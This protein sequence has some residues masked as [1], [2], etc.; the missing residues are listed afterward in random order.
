MSMQDPIADLLTRIRNGQMAGKVEVQMPHSKVK[1][2]LCNVLIEEGYLQ[3]CEAVGEEKKPELKVVLKYFEGAPVIE[4]IKRISR[5][6][7]RVFKGKD[8]IPK[9]NG[10][11]GTAIISSNKG[12]LSDRAAREQGVGG[13]IL[14]TVS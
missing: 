1:Q 7:L 12:I 11:L 3:S 6:G 14:C 10:G 5:P 2:A 13:E 8:E 4:K 9:V